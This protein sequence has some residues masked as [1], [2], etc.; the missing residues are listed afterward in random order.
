MTRLLDLWHREPVAL[1][2]ALRSTVERGL[3]LLVLFGVPLTTEQL[4]GIL[5]FFGAVWGVL[6]IV[7]RGK[8]TP[9]SPDAEP[10]TKE[11]IQP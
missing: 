9:W 1:F 5:T 8:V 4:A 10:L 6:T 11:T 7:V 3:L 2:E